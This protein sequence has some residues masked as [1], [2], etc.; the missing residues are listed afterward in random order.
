MKT[1]FIILWLLPSIC[2]AQALTCTYTAGTP[3]QAA[4]P[5]ILNQVDQLRPTIYDAP[6]PATDE[7]QQWQVFHLRADERVVLRDGHLV[8][9]TKKRPLWARI[10]TLGILR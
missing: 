5:D 9:V 3:V 1:L 2:S 10:L 7:D 8:V 6:T 4:E